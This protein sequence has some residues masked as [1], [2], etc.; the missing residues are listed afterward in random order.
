M[1]EPSNGQTC[2]GGG[3]ADAGRELR[4]LMLRM[5]FD[6][7]LEAYKSIRDKVPGV[8]RTFVPIAEL[9]GIVYDLDDKLSHLLDSKY[10]YHIALNVPVQ[11]V[12]RRQMYRCFVD[13]NGTK[14]LDIMVDGERIW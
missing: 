11:F 3:G 14:W 9:R 7:I 4:E 13:R 6:E 8:R 10:K 12:R 1:R 5:Y 2:N